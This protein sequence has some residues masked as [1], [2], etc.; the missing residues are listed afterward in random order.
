MGKGGRSAGLETIDEVPSPLTFDFVK[1]APKNGN[2]EYEQLLA[3]K[4]IDILD[5][6][7]ET[8]IRVSPHR[9]WVLFVFGFAA[10]NQAMVW[11]ILSPSSDE[12]VR[13]RML[14]LDKLSDSSL[15][16]VFK[17]S[18]CDITFPDKSSRRTFM[19]GRRPLIF[20]ILSAGFPDGDD[21]DRRAVS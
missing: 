21:L 12:F 20:L 5:E 13:L 4:H 15:T 17:P 1:D 2:G 6:N 8:I 19:Y 11:M 3:E 7:N 16:N 9:W 18:T 14:F 10:V